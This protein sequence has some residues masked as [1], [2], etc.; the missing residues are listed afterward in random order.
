[1]SE[2]LANPWVQRAVLVVG[3][4]LVGLLLE[5]AVLSRLRALAASS[6][7]LWDDVLVGSL[8]GVTTVLLSAVGIYFALNVPPVSRLAETTVRKVLVVVVIAALV[9]AVMRVVAGAVLAVAKNSAVRSPTLVVNVARLVVGVLGFFII[10]QNLDIDITPLITALGIGGLAVALALQDTLGN[11]FAGMQIVLGRQVRTGDYIRLASGE[12]GFVTDVKGRNTTV[13]TFPDGNLVVIPNSSLANSIVK[14]F[15]LPRTA[16]WVSVDVG[17]SYDSDLEKVEAVTLEV[18]REVMRE[19]GGDVLENPPRVLFHTFGESSIDFEARILA[20]EFTHQGI[21]RSQFVK[22]LHRRFQEEG[23]EIPFPIRTLV[24]KN[25]QAVP[26]P[27]AG[28]RGAPAG[29]GTEVPP[30]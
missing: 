8:R 21:I 27:A 20:S 29:N 3:G 16:L 13:E 1:M 23:I 25:P 7:R 30:P 26:A 9:V 11:L 6:S 2:I 5:G 15:S 4:V 19:A 14:N 28:D 12:E 18:A 22:R 17:V 10:L 24:L